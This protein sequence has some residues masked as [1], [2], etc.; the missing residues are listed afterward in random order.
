M[1]SSKTIPRLVEAR[2]VE[3]LDES[4][5]VLIHGPHQSG[6]TTL[7]PQITTEQIR[8]PLP[9]SDAVPFDWPPGEVATTPTQE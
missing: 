1:E 5:A 6:K 9:S 7:V 4:P 3:T 8:Q 2:L